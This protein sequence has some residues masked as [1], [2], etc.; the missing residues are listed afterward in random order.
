MKKKIILYT[1]ALLLASLLV[2]CGQYPYYS[3]ISTN[4]NNAVTTSGRYPQNQLVATVMG[5]VKLD[6]SAFVLVN[7]FV[8]GIEV[9]LQYGTVNNFTKQKI[10]DFTEAYLRYG[11]AEKLKAVADML[12]P[13]GLGLRLWDAFR[14]VSAQ[15]KLYEAYPDS[16]VVSHPVTGYRGHCRGNAVDVTLIDLATGEALAMPTGFDNFTAYADRDY[17]DCGTTTAANAR[18]LED[19]MTECGFKPLQSEW[20]HFT[21]TDTYPVDEYFEPGTPTAWEANCNE[22]ISLRK[23]AGSTEVLTKIPA[24]ATVTLQ[25]WDGRY[26]KVSYGDKEGYVLSSYIKPTD[27]SY[28]NNALSVVAW[29]STYTY[30]QMQADIAQLKQIYSNALT[31]TTMGT[32]E[33]GRDIPV[34]RIGQENARY[35]VLF[36]GTIHGREHMTAW[37]LMALADYWLAHDIQS[38]GD[39]CYHIIPMINPDGA[40]ISQTGILTAQQESIYQNDK[41]NGYTSLSKPEYAN[42]WKAN[43]LGTDLNRNFP[44]GWEGITARTAASSEKYRGEKPFSAAETQYLRDYTLKYAFDATFSYHASGSLIYYEYGL[45]ESTNNSSKSL[46]EAVKMVTGYPLEGSSAVDGAGYKDWTIDALEIPSLTIEI[47]CESTPLAKRELYSIFVRNRSVLPE[48]A[49]WVQD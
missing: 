2:G 6:N 27:P 26:A 21:D 40:T 29:D 32:S 24:G 46:A 35:H 33:L 19:V 30:A 10:Y 15:K 1:A 45:N 14:P 37:L 20:W 38:Y 39:V 13:L 48:V 43:G 9:A 18:L 3:D 5:S 7:E 12:K 47:G 4:A 44:S 8:P 31:V 17:S 22:Y 49:R 42:A 41:A 11:T 36:Q 25:S 34:L 23:T 16:N 28:L